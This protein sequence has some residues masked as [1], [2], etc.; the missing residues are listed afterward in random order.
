MSSA[1]LI[2]D[3][4]TSIR[5][6]MAAYLEDEGFHAMVVES[7]EEAVSLLDLKRV[8]AAIVDLRLPGMNGEAFIRSVYDRFPNMVFVIYTGSPEYRPTADIVRLPRV[9]DTVFLKPIEDLGLLVAEL[10]RLIA[11]R[12]DEVIC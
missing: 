9:A 7:G 12:G 3:D 4:D 2:L 10:R 8:D 6:S 5:E 1:I 11:E